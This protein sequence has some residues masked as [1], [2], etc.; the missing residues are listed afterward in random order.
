MS[1][2]KQLKAAKTQST[3]APSTQPIPEWVAD[4]VQAGWGHAKLSGIDVALPMPSHYPKSSLG[5]GFA[6][7]ADILIGL[8]TF[9]GGEPARARLTLWGHTLFE[10]YKSQIKAGLMPASDEFYL[11]IALFKGEDALKTVLEKRGYTVYKI[12]NNLMTSTSA[13]LGAD[14]SAWDL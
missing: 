7:F 10:K 13:P 4:L 12:T 5:K 6:P 14:M 2:F 9:I 8:P 3:E 1:F 11:L